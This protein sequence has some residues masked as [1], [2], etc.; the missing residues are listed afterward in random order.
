MIGLNMLPEKDGFGFE[1]S[2][3]IRRV[4]GNV[5]QLHPG[6]KVIFLHPSVFSNR[7]IVPEALVAPIPTGL[8]LEQ[9]T[10]VGCAYVTAAYCLLNVGRLSKGQVSAFNPRG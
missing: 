5:S 3:L 9:A 6:D 8:S 1:G 10:T 2:G 7:I 4:G